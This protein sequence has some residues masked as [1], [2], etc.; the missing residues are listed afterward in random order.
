MFASPTFTGTVAGVTATHVGLG[1]VTNESKAT[2]FASPT[3]TGTTTLQQSTEVLNT[4]T[5]AT[6]YVN[7]DYS[8]G[9]V[10][11]HSSISANFTA[12]FTNVPTT[13]NRTIVCTLILSQ[14]ATAYIP[15]VV[16]IGGVGQTIK[17]LGNVEPPGNVNKI[18]IVSFSMIRTGSAWTVL[19][20]LS[21]YG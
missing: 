2:M 17:W 14:G 8:T 3:F 12:G 16:Q 15:N 5:S 13:D 9:S 1:N 6:G 21:T 7:H 10:W 4:K 20:S 11:Y 19:G 18:D